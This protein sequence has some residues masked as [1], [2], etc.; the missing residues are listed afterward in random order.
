ML[1]ALSFGFPCCESDQLC[2]H[3]YKLSKPIVISQDGIGEKLEL[4]HWTLRAGNQL[5][6]TLYNAGVWIPVD[7][8][9]PAVQSG[10]DLLDPG[11]HH[12][13]IK[14]ST[15]TC[16]FRMKQNSKE[17][18]SALARMAAEDKE[19]LFKIRPKLHLFGHIV[20]LDPFKNM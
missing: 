4:L 7:D 1:R 19:V 14:N 16:A 20:L 17:G 8:E 18:F 10:F 3:K 11:Q 13:K 6:H 9:R 15:D 12:F 2:V 5:F